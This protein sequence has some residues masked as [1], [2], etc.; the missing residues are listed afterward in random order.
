MKTKAV[1]RG[2]LTSFTILSLAACGGGSTSTTADPKDADATSADALVI[3]ELSTYDAR[4]IEI[5][6]CPNEFLGDT[7]GCLSALWAGDANLFIGPDR[8]QLLKIG[9][10]AVDPPYSSQSYA[11]PGPGTATFIDWDTLLTDAEDKSNHARY[12]F[13]AGPDPSAFPQANSC[14]GSANVLSKMDVTA[15][16]VSNNATYAYFA[17]QR[18]SNEGDAGYM[19]LFTKEVPLNPAAGGCGPTELRYRLT[20]GDVMFRGHFVSDVTTKLLFI[21]TIP[22]GTITTGKTVNVDN[23]NFTAVCPGGG[24]PCY[25]EMP[26][27]SAINWENGLWLEKSDGVAAAAVNSDPAGAGH[28]GVEGVVAAMAQND[29]E[30]IGTGQNAQQWKCTDPAG[31]MESYLIAE[32]AVPTAIFT[33][34]GAVCGATFYGS[35][36]TRPSGNQPSPDM[37]DL[38]G[39]YQFNFG[40]AEVTA[41][42]SPSCD[43]EFGYG[44]SSFTGLG[45]STPTT[46]TWS[47]KPAGAPDSS[48]VVFDSDCD[49]FTAEEF[50]DATGANL[51]GSYTLKVVAG[52]GFCSAEDTTT[53]NVYPV[54][55]VAASMTGS[56]SLN[57]TYGG[58]GGGGSGDLTYGWAFS[59]PGTTTPT[60]SSTLD[61][62]VGDPVEVSLAGSYSGILT[63]TDNRTDI[64]G[65]NDTAPASADVYAP[66]LVS[67]AATPASLSCDPTNPDADIST[68][69]LYTATK[70]GGSGSFTYVWGGA[71]SGTATNDNT[72]DVNDAT[73]CQDETLS[74]YVNDSIC[75]NT[76][77][78]TGTYA[79]TTT[80]TTSVT[81][82]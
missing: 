55:T 2:I 38:A 4:F 73:T 79:K 74:V 66:V 32:V 67:L 72:C 26:A 47:Y 23:T 50:F 25:I 51:N 56:C 9:K 7:L 24:A 31:C 71:C 54:V 46:C 42:A 57:F 6:A 77:T 70:T 10:N 14:T 37:K 76:S 61:N 41:A 15:V 68:A 11:Y 45:I 53:V 62:P 19:W 49:S 69:A 5:D 33:G 13:S 28:L 44:I 27:K 64:T 60:S 36:I 17:V 35:V 82:P 12:D 48:Y 3:E 63:V 43:Q 52:D 16:T 40:S 21:Y 34:G 29:T 81:N 58:T 39:P 78:S 80:V 59:G 75:G 20:D 18:S 30:T 22:P 1:K 8:D 65:C